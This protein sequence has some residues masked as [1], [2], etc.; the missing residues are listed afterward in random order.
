MDN[1]KK[2]NSSGQLSRSLMLLFGKAVLLPL[3]IILINLSAYAAIILRVEFVMADAAM[4]GFFHTLNLCALPGTLAAL[5]VFRV[6][7]L[8]SSRWEYAGE[9]ELLNIG[10][11]SVCASAF[12]YTIA[13]VL[14]CA[15]PRSF[16]F[17]FAMLLF[18]CVA[19]SRFIFRRQS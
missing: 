15:L 7:R 11:A 10:F 4:L 2:N 5:I 9:K 8:Y 18:V 19:G 16:P 13:F 3:D 6:F 12:Y 14:K 1:S 17:L